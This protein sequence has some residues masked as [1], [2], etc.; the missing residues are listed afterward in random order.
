MFFLGKSKKQSNQFHS[1]FG[2]E[3]R[4]TTRLRS[5]AELS[6][7]AASH[8]CLFWMCRLPD[9]WSLAWRCDESGTSQMLQRPTPYELSSNSLLGRARTLLSLALSSAITRPLHHL[10][11]AALQHVH[12]ILNHAW[13]WISSGL[14]DLYGCS[15]VP[16]HM[17]LCRNCLKSS[18]SRHR[19]DE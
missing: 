1:M 2:A 13:G 16:R 14:Q 7:M 18:L 19:G 6:F 12:E 17:K 4:L 10:R 3:V 8:A 5:A 15:V 11:R 9:R